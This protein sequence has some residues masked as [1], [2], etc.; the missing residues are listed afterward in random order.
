M[1]G[2]V[3]CTG[4]P[5]TFHTYVSEMVSAASSSSTVAVAV[6]VSPVAGAPSDSTTVALGAEFDT[7]MGSLVAGAEVRSPSS[8]VARTRITSPAS[9]LPARD[10]SRL[11]SVAPEI[12]DPLANHW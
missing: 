7:V 1:V 3:V 9:P 2:P 11:E 12:G 4:V 8:T 10:R 5:L 6:S